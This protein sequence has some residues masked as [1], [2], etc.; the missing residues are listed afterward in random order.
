MT[1][2]AAQFDVK[3]IYFY[4]FN[5]YYY[6][7]NNNIQHI[8]KQK[9]QNKKEKKKDRKTIYNKQNRCQGQGRIIQWALW[10]R[11]QG[12]SEGK[13]KNEECLYVKCNS[14]HQCLVDNRE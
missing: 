1:S 7:K 2:D 4:F 8:I 9:K 12:P 13:K 11:A 6:S 10:A 5:Y 14:A 3:E